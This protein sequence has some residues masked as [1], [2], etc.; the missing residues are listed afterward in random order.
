MPF[1]E[2]Y[3]DHSAITIR[4][5]TGLNRGDMM[6]L[7]AHTDPQMRETAISR[8]PC[9]LCHGPLVGRCLVRWAEGSTVHEDCF[10]H[11]SGVVAVKSQ[12]RRRP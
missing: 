11:Y 1:S 3:E 6:D 2:V 7:W 5:P 4:G 12:T 10:Q 9:A 8:R